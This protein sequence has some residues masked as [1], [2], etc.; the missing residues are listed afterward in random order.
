M[1]AQC[2]NGGCIGV[3]QQGYSR[4]KD[5][6]GICKEAQDIRS[7][8]NLWTEVLDQPRRQSV[9]K[10]A[11]PLRQN[12]YM[13]KDQEVREHAV[14]NERIRERIEQDIKHV[15]HKKHNHSLEQNRQNHK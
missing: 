8:K 1:I 3:V 11:R 10:H 13:E 6:C 4:A 9:V 15:R 2:D 5:R 14:R 12:Q 7:R